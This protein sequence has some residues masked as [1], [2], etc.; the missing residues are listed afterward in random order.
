MVDQ[1]QFKEEIKAKFKRNN[2]GC[3]TNWKYLLQISSSTS[4]SNNQN[5]RRININSVQRMGSHFQHNGEGGFLQFLHWPGALKLVDLTTYLVYLPRWCCKIVYVLSRD[6]IMH[7]T[8]DRS[9]CT[10]NVINVGRSPGLV[11]MGGDLHSRGCE[12]ESQHRILDVHYSH[13]FVVKI[14]MFVWKRLKIN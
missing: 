7:W 11:V 14:V 9:F 3:Q 13:I 5:W 4:F 6:D 1:H 10:L 12:F 2:F 8:L